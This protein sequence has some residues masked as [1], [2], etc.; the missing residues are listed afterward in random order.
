MKKKLMLLLILTFVGMESVLAQTKVTGTVLSDDDG[1]PIVGASVLVTGTKTGTIT[2]EDGVF[3]LSNLPGS[4]KSLT[5]S[6]I[7]MKSQTVSIKNG[8]TMRIVLKSDSR[9]L[10]EV[11]V[12]ALGISKG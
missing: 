3:T 12:T 10:N 11:V 7:G 2:N 5:I 8:A 1:L 4:A 9:T 6:Y